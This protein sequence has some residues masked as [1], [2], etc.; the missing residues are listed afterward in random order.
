M[1][2]TIDAGPAPAT[3]AYLPTLRDFAAAD[4]IC[5]IGRGREVR[6]VVGRQ[7]GSLLAELYSLWAWQFGDQRVVEDTDIVSPIIERFDREPAAESVVLVAQN[8]WNARPF[9][10]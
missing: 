7:A 1:F 3:V 9:S 10:S 4:E 5:S 6:G 2:A 8:E